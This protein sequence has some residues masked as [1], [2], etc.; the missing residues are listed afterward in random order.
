MK[1]DI[2]GKKLYK[3]F[4]LSTFSKKK[5][6]FIS[7]ELVGL[8]NKTA[9]GLTGKPQTPNI[10]HNWYTYWVK[11]TQTIGTFAHKK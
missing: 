1:I 9:N 6:T 7:S 11:E 8:T 3:Q 4:E 2:P 5:C 10:L